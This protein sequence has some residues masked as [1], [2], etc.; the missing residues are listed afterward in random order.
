MRLHDA[1]RQNIDREL[2]LRNLS[3][4]EL[5]RRCKMPP[6]RISEAIQGTHCPTLNTVERI[7]SGLGISAVSLLLPP[8]EHAEVA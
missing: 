7:A 5:A 6:P 1:F 4:A 8:A 2:R 3:Q